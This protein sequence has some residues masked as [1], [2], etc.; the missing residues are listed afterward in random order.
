VLVAVAQRVKG[1]GAAGLIRCAGDRRPVCD[2]DESC[3]F[4][5]HGGK[6]VSALGVEDNLT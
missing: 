1:P 2:V 4:R 6:L 3:V 5:V